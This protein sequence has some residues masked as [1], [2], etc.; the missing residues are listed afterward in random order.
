MV[1]DLPP[2]LRSLAVHANYLIR[3]QHPQKDP[4]GRLESLGLILMEKVAHLA[5]AG[6]GE[7]LVHLH[8]I[9]AQQG[10]TQVV[11]ALDRIHN[12]FCRFK[13]YSLTFADGADKILVKVLHG[14]VVQAHDIEATL[15][16]V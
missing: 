11:C 7:F 9:L 10:R 8:A 16:K 14:R 5:Q 6:P 4:G 1:E 12:D 15:V 2:A 13:V 3:G